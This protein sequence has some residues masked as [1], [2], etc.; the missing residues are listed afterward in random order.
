MKSI[1]LLLLIIVTHIC[2]FSQQTIN[3][4]YKKGALNI[5]LPKTPESAGFEKYGNIPVNEATGTMSLSIPL[6]NLKGNFLEVPI[7]LSYNASGIKVNQEASWV[8]LGFDLIAGGRITVEVKG[9]IDNDG[10]TAGLIPGN[11][12]SEFERLLNRLKYSPQ[13]PQ[14]SS[15]VEEYALHTFAST[16]QGCDIN[17]TNNIP[18]HW[19]T[20]N[21]MAQFGIGEPDVFRA[22]FLGQSLAFYFDRL[23][24]EI[25][26]IGEKSNVRIQVNREQSQSGLN[27][28]LHQY[29]KILDWVI[30]DT[31]GIKYYFVDKEE[32]E[33]TFPSYG[34]LYGNKSTTAWL[35]N[36]IVHPSGEE[37]NFTYKE[38]GKTYPAFSWSAS[39]SSGGGAS[40]ENEQYQSIQVPKYLSSIEGGNTLIEFIPSSR[41]DLKGEGARKLD[42]INV[43]DRWTGKL[44]NKIEFEYDYFSADQLSCYTNIRLD[45][46]NRGFALNRLKLNK[47]YLN[48]VD[49]KIPPYQFSYFTT[50]IPDKYTFS[51]DHWGFYNGA[52]NSFY[53]DPCSP[54]NLIPAVTNYFSGISTALPQYSNYNTFISATTGYQA[55]RNC[56]GAFMTSMSLKEVIYPTGGRSVFE[57]E[58]HSEG[59]SGLTGGGLRIKS[60]KNYNGNEQVNHTEYVYGTGNFK[61]RLLYQTASYQIGACRDVV[62]TDRINSTISNNGF[63]HEDDNVILYSDVSVYTKDRNGNS[64]GYVKKIFKAST[65]DQSNP[66]GCNQMPAHWPAGIV[67][68]PGNGTSLTYDNSLTHL[69]TQYSAIAPTPS[70][71]L[72]GKILK[73]EY[74]N[75][76]NNIVKTIE[77]QYNL[78]DYNSRYFSIRCIDNRIGGSDAYG[79][80]EGGEP[81]DF[82]T[83]GVR[84]YSIYVSPAKSYYT[85]STGTIEKGIENGQ[86]YTLSK[87]MEYNQFYQPE[88]II[89]LNSDGTETI[90]YIKTI[91]S[92]SSEPLNYP[93]SV[94]PNDIDS[95][96]AARHLRMQNA[97]DLPLEESVLRKNT[98][99]TIELI[100]SK[101][102]AYKPSAVPYK[103]YVSENKSPRAWPGQFMPL[104]FALNN[105]L[106][107]LVFD[108]NYYRLEE[109]Q[110]HNSIALPVEYNS[111]NGKLAF[112]WDGSNNKLIARVINA[113]IDE[114]AFS[115][116]ETSEHGGWDYSGQPRLYFDA[117]TGKYI[118]PLASSDIH[119][120]SSIP[121]KKSIVSAWK[122]GDVNI[123]G[124]GQY[125]RNK[126]GANGWEYVEYLLEDVS[127]ITISG[128]GVIDE[129]RLYPFSSAMTTFVHDNY[130][131]VLCQ[132]D[133]NGNS[134]YYDYDQAGRLLLVRDQ[135][136]KIIKK[137]C[138]VYDSKA[139]CELFANTEQTVILQKN[140]CPDPVH[141]IGGT[142]SYTVPAATYYSTV[143]T[144]EA[145]SRA[146]AEI[147]E[148][149]QNYVNQHANPGCIP[150]FPIYLQ[151]FGTV[152]YSIEVT[153]TVTGV[154]SSFI[155]NL[156]QGVNQLFGKVVPGTYHIRIYPTH[157]TSSLLMKLTYNGIESFNTEFNINSYVIDND[158]SFTI[159]EAI[160]CTFLPY[161]GWSSVNSNFTPS[162]S[163]ISFNLSLIKPSSLVIS[164]Q[165]GLHVIGT[166]TGSCIPS[167]ERIVAVSDGNA[168]WEM[169]VGTTGVISIQL[170]N[171]TAP[172]GND[173]IQ[174]SGTYLK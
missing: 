28:A 140:D 104:H 68:D 99:N 103:V 49:G 72:E 45:Q 117:P 31:R 11:F 112:L 14:S 156:Q 18:D 167:T 64:E 119:F 82:L 93:L 165:S 147:E 60:V 69:Y 107:Q 111:K 98:D 39:Y 42:A 109:E 142:F 7:S 24:G 158:L 170:I 80:P 101:Y 90:Q 153:N 135:D 29:Q 71:G 34:G 127:D 22:N 48:G 87:Q 4:D 20:V 10:V 6:Y 118:Y 128:T 41:E 137:L 25:N 61:G 53:S 131:G 100:S 126:Q 113:G 124:S 84:R 149:A 73:E 77:Y 132:T 159:Q 36:K 136:K 95:Y 23:T 81:M 26:F 2:C 96:T 164:T 86:E 144:E 110:K 138:Y 1:S 9:S 161:T 66:L 123:N 166:V 115:S 65:I 46:A 58:P 56:N 37:I 52:I 155:L 83:N 145:N 89:T 92:I 13:F 163:S 35:L 121:L 160:S 50:S 116:F 157:G 16:C 169:H 143:S 21:A 32:T 12:N 125:L 67:V 106:G 44:K 76:D 139:E 38:E 91:A 19:P 47:L 74:R 59:S 40:S 141:Y 51:Q 78:G 62:L 63:L 85:L 122:K 120:H 94:D 168:S 33:V 55:N 30:T 151:N 154:T 134:I 105:G 75:S 171:G 150:A 15:N 8:G 57:F 148:N 114:I 54:Q 17:L 173:P 102:T 43:L 162:P 146:N 79:C 27:Q 133:L 129:L 88:K 70:R 97:V 172:S 152:P 130:L 5:A 174:L 3:G 108:Q